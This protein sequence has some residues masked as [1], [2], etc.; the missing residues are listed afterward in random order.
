[1]KC[2]KFKWILDNTSWFWFTEV[3]SKDDEISWLLRQTM[4]P[5]LPCNVSADYEFLEVPH[6]LG[7][8]NQL[9]FVTK[10]RCHISRVMYQLI[11]VTHG[12]SEG[13]TF[14]W[15]MNSADFFVTKWRFNIS[16]ARYQLIIVIHGVSEDPTSPWCMKST[17]WRLGTFCLPVGAPF[18]T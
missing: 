11:I 13:S 5:H 12:V 3:L 4:V 10:W 6:F 7:V 16:R 18:S 17:T 9:I 14:P 8:R 15:C 1:M 2:L